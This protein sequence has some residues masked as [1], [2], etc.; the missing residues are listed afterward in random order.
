LYESRAIGY[1]IATKY[2]DQGT[3]GL[4]PTELKAAALFQ[5]AWSVE[6]WDFSQ[7]AD[8][9]NHEALIKPLCGVKTDQAVVDGH[10]A[11]VNK[12]LD[13]YEKILSKQKYL[14]GDVRIEFLAS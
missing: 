2:A 12:N 4:V 11:K 8:K 9:A 10:L 13:V 7:D 3:P 1:Y 14:A 6:V 5:Q